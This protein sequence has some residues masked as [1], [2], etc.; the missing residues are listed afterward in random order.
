MGE[1][2]DD[3]AGGEG[4]N[5][6]QRAFAGGQRRQHDALQRLVILAQ[7]GIAEAAAHFR[8][9]RA[10]LLSDLVHSARSRP[11][12][13]R[14]GNRKPSFTLPSAA[15]P[16][17]PDQQRPVESTPT[18]RS[19]SCDRSSTIDHVDWVDALGRCPFQPLR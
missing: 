15:R 5:N 8:L 2:G 1:A 12:N 3:L 16:P 10:E 4:L 6:R 11:A 17:D 9:N 7:S 13:I 14:C 19:I 18:A